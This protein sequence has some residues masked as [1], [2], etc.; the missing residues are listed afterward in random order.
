[1]RGHS[2]LRSLCSLLL[3]RVPTLLVRL[4]LVTETSALN[5]VQFSIPDSSTR[6]LWAGRLAIEEARSRKRDPGSAI[7]EARFEMIGASVPLI[8]SRQV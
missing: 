8:I 1:M 7:Q 5:L 6:S 2:P 3:R 4:L